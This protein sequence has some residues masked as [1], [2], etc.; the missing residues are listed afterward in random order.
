MKS[1]SRMKRMITILLAAVITLSMSIA[2][3]GADGYW[4][5][6]DYGWWYQNA[7]GTYPCGSW[8][9]IDGSWYHFN[10]MIFP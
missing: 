5:A 8:Q 10:Y 4:N 7:D 6:D 3:F 9:F 1:S 2:V